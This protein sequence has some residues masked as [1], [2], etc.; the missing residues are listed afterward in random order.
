MLIRNVM[1]PGDFTHRSWCAFRDWC[2][3]IWDH[4]WPLISDT[5]CCICRT[6]L[7]NIVADVFSNPYLYRRLMIMQVPL[8]AAMSSFRR[9]ARIAD[10]IVILCT[11]TWGSSDV[12]SA[13]APFWQHVIVFL[14]MQVISMH[15]QSVQKRKQLHCGKAGLSLQ[16]SRPNEHR[17][18]NDGKP[19]G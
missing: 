13:K 14:R 3:P 9:W 1:M 17:Q 10:Y 18:I 5:C 11:S 19:F 6:I 16:W 4:I 7:A 2:V 12:G 8:T 15:Q